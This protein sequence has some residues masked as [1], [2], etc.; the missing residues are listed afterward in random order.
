MMID[1]LKQSLTLRKVCGVIM[2]GTI[3]VGHNCNSERKKKFNVRFPPFFA[4][5]NL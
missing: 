5:Y 3:E 1:G 2:G 4:K